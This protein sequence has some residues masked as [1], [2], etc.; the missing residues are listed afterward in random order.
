MPL[1]SR[2]AMNLFR[3]HETVVA[4]WADAYLRLALFQHDPPL[5]KGPFRPEDLPNLI[6]TFRD[7]VAYTV[8]RL[9]TIRQEIRRRGLT[10]PELPSGL[11]AIDQE[12]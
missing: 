5:P 3:D 2:L 12:D 10:P 7:I 8:T 4:D 11:A 1:E 6:I 9:R